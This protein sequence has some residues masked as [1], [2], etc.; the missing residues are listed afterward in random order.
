MTTRD[1]DLVQLRWQ[2]IRAFEQGLALENENIDLRRQ[3]ALLRSNKEGDTGRQKQALVEFAR[4][5]L[6]WL[7][8]TKHEMMQMKSVFEIEV[9]ASVRI[10]ATIKQQLEKMMKHA[11]IQDSLTKNSQGEKYR[12]LT[13]LEDARQQA[14]AANQ[15]KAS[16]GE[17]LRLKVSKLREQLGE[18]D[19][20]KSRITATVE[21][22]QQAAQSEA[23]KL[24]VRGGLWSWGYKA[25]VE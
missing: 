6:A 11:S 8:R 25:C 1:L 24:E 4:T 20:A 7:K 22:L 17:R 23:T 15:S 2:Q 14:A 13:E 16:E 12:L 9:N 19:Y 3:I 18:A 10:H 21:E 5:I